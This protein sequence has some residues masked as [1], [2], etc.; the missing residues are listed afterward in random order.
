MRNTRKRIEAAL[1]VALFSMLGILL[2]P[3]VAAADTVAA[4]TTRCT[5]HRVP[6]ALPDGSHRRVFGEL[7]LPRRGKPAPPVQVLLHGGTYDHRYWDWP[8]RS[9]R[10]SYVRKATEQGYATFNLDRLGY[11]RSDRIDG[12]L[13]DFELSGAVVH[14]VVQALRS[15]R[16]GPRFDTVVLNGHSMGAIT[17]KWAAALGGVD[18]LV[19]SGIPADPPGGATR[20]D[21]PTASPADAFHPASQDPKFA[22]RWWA[23]SYLTTRPGVRTGLFLEGGTYEWFVAVQEELLRET[24]PVG[25]LRAVSSDDKP[26]PTLAVPTF[27][28]IGRY[29]A[30]HCA[31]TGD[32]R[33][34]PGGAH[35]D[36]IVEDAGHS[37]NLTAGAKRFHAATFRWLAR[38]GL[39]PR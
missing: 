35:A 23:D 33:T 19:V 10:Y 36:L 28:A 32:C 5:M 14:Q 9:K 31:G 7:C 6:V 27:H 34:D 30:L 39:A 15:G 11:G 29:D 17:A 4:P 3:P 2:A 8:Y 22:G 1:A 25:E 18:A 38:Q 24:V 37:I 20:T 26:A 12:D 13:I 21:E 16:L